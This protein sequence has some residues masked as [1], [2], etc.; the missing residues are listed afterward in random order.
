MNVESVSIVIPIW[1]DPKYTDSCL[2][3]LVR[4]ASDYELIL[5][6]N[7]NG[8][9]VKTPNGLHAIFRNP[10][11]L[12]FAKGCN[13]GAAA[14]TGEVLCFLNCDTEGT[15]DWLVTLLEAFDDPNVAMAG[16]RIEHF[17]GTLQTAGIRTWHGNGSAGGEEIKDELPTRD[18][19]GVTGACMAI[20]RDV[21][22]SLGGFD[23]AFVNGY[24]D[25]AL[26]LSVREAGHRIRYVNKSVIKHWESVSPGRWTHALQNVATMNTKWGNR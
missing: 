20:R 19:D 21:F 7:T 22:K 3:S 18:V 10:E 13:Q 25:V 15:F 16:P 6:D 9:D 17:D 8:Y 5:V 4:T 23:E 1:G 26:C 24:E 14:A 2:T 11:N 12:G